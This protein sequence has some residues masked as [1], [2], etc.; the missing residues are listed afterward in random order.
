[1]KRYRLTYYNS[2]GFRTT[3][4]LETAYELREGPNNEIS[5][6]DGDRCVGDVTHLEKLLLDQLGWSE[7]IT[8]VRFETVTIGAADPS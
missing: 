8:V 5:V 6:M 1:M 4:E 7:E 2:G 3:A